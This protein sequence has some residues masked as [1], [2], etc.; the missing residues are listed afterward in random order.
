MEAVITINIFVPTGGESVSE[1]HRNK[2]E[3][4]RLDKIDEDVNVI[5]DKMKRELESV[6]N[7]LTE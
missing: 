5:A 3:T 1:I 7:A 2:V 6:K 4:V